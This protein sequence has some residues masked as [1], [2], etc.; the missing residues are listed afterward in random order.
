M[1]TL[2]SDCFIDAKGSYNDLPNETTVQG[3]RLANRVFEELCAD[4]KIVTTTDY[5]IFDGVTREYPIPVTYKALWSCNLVLSAMSAPLALVETSRDQLDQ[6]SPGWEFPQAS[7]PTQWYTD[8]GPSGPVIGFDWIQAVPTTPANSTGFPIAVYTASLFT[9]LT[10][11]SSIPTTL[12]SPEVIIAGLV[13]RWGRMRGKSDW[14]AKEYI[15]I[16]KI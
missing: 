3:L 12:K 5:V 4:F 13:A 7:Q 11:G 10:A 6:E 9:P 2:L 15:I 16:Q 1:A 8:S 14:Q